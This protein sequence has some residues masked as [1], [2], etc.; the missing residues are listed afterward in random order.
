MITFMRLAKSIGCLASALS[1]MW[2]AAAGA[3]SAVRERIDATPQSPPLVTDDP[4]V[5]DDGQYEINFTTD[6]DAT[7]R[8]SRTNLL[9][10]DANYGLR[11]VINGRSCLCRSSSSVI[12]AARE[13]GSRTRGLG[14]AASV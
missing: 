9:T 13:A 7:R 3:Q 5:P 2:P 1:L 4:G 11:L 14:A 10:V 6:T 12:G 8:A